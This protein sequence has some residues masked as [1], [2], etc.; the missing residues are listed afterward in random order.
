[1]SRPYKSF[2]RVYAPTVIDG[3]GMYRCR[4]DDVF[5]VFV[6]MTHQF[7]EGNKSYPYELWI[8]Y[9]AELPV[10]GFPTEERAMDFCKHHSNR[11]PL[12][13]Q[14]QLLKIRDQY[15]VANVLNSYYSVLEMAKAT[16][17]YDSQM[18]EL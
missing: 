18:Q 10:W 8:D 11:Y 1:M 3:W 4:V 17:N 16:T 15:W 6:C 12:D 5:N 13:R 14:L 9:M 7:L 2:V